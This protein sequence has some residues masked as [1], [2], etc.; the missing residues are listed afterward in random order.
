MCACGEELVL[1]M[2][3]LV[4]QPDEMP[5]FAYGELIERCQQLTELRKT[6]IKLEDESVAEILDE[7]EYID[8]SETENY[9]TIKIDENAFIEDTIKL[10]LDHFS[11]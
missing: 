5:E 6:Q 7:C 9:L 4:P 11:D 2:E 10:A 8:G 1:D 3:K